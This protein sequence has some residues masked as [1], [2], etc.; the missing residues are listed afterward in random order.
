M[1]RDEDLLEAPDLTGKI[2]IVDYAP[3]FFGPYSH[4]FKGFYSG[5]PVSCALS[6]TDCLT[7][8]Q[9]AIKVLRYSGLS[10]PAIKRVGESINQCFI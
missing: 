7:I 9:V 8:S 3:V 4:I 1:D 5:E 2:T 10:L 6:P